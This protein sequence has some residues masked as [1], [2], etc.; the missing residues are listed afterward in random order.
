MP[1]NYRCNFR[2]KPNVIASV[3]NLKHYSMQCTRRVSDSSGNRNGMCVG[4]LE[5]IARPRGRGRVCRLI[6]A[7]PKVFKIILNHFNLFSYSRFVH[8]DGA[9]AAPEHRDDWVELVLGRGLPN[10]LPRR[11]FLHSLMFVHC[12]DTLC[13]HYDQK[14][15][16]HCGKKSDETVFLFAH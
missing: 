5:R 6:G 12:T 9:L 13:H 7:T 14:L 16:A 15:P 11:P 1:V 10:F 4:L 3:N 2:L 8:L